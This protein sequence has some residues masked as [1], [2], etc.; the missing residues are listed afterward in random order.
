VAEVA[1]KLLT[2]VA[3]LVAVVVEPLSEALAWCATTCR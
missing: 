2:V 1:V 3:A